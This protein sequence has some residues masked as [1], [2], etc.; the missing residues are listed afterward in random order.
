MANIPNPIKP[1]IE[2]NTTS[3]ISK[4]PVAKI[5]C[6]ISMKIDTNGITYI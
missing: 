2:F 5:N 4:E 1:P 6:V 3:S